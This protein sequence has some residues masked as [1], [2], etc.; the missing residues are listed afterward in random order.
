MELVRL[1]MM[2]LR[3]NRMKLLEKMPEEDRERIMVHNYKEVDKREDKNQ[4]RQLTG[5]RECPEAEEESFSSIDSEEMFVGNL[6][7]K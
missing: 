6:A 4:L 2:L 1:N 5:I 7:S 3:Q